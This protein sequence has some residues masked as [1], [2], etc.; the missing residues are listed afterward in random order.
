[1]PQ[2]IVTRSP[3]E[4]SDQRVPGDRGDDGGDR[5]P[6]LVQRGRQAEHELVPA[7]PGEPVALL[8]PL[9]Q[10]PAD[11]PE[12]LVA[13][14]VAV[15]VV[16]HLE[17]VDVE[18][19][20][21]Q[22]LAGG[23]HGRHQR[24]QLGVERPPVGQ[25]G[26]RVGQRVR[27]QLPAAPQQRLLLDPQPGRGLPGLPAL[28]LGLPVP[29]VDHAIPVQRVGGPAGGLVDPGQQQRHVVGAGR[30]RPADR[31]PQPEQDPAGLVEPA[32]GEQRGAL[33]VRE[34][35]AQ[36]RGLGLDRH[37]RG[38]PQLLPRRRRVAE[39]AG[40]QRALGAGQRAHHVRQR[41]RRGQRRL[42]VPHDRLPAPVALRRP[43]RGGRGSSPR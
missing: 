9:P 15:P 11:H 4:T 17:P 36:R 28:L 13:D 3:G 27:L 22:R 24:G 6:G 30:H 29:A 34:Q 12:H 8:A 35:P 25:P 14:R 33:G 2:P 16:D 7:V 18:H 38:L 20:Q 43:G 1:M 19:G 21:A 39:P 23:L 40:Q 32:L 5:G 37:R 10:H 42:V 26:E 31:L 41:V